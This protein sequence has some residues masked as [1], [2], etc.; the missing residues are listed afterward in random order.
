MRRLFV[1]TVLALTLA[2]CAEN[3]EEVRAS[4]T[5]TDTGERAREVAT[6]WNGSQAAA[7]WQSGY[8][9]T[10]DWVRYP[11]G[12]E[13]ATLTL[14]TAL[15]SPPSG[16]ARVKWPDGRTLT[17]PLQPAATAYDI[18]NR[19]A[20]YGPQ[21]TVT[22]VKL[23]ET[24]LPTSRGPATVPAW[25]FTVDGYN[26]PVSRAAVLPS[27]LP[28]RPLPG[29]AAPWTVSRLLSVRG[30]TVTVV[31]PH[32]SCDAGASVD[33]LETPGSV[34]LT[35]SVGDPEPGACIA[36]LEMEPVTV[37]LAAPLGNRVLLDAST[38]T[39]LPYDLPN[40]LSPSWS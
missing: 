36:S 3:P 40:S 13:N 9:P 25:L 38:A 30:S 35:A 4:P 11:K 24:T 2:A 20:G 5:P 31:V 23:G 12:A 15:P 1:L 18:L 19:H 29:R 7:S 26:T 27:K 32:G 21:L 28:E 22:S 16:P 6:A 14:R 17:R 8:H 39:P 34:V 33:A 37:R 10:G